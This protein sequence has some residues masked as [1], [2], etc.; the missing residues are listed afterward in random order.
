MNITV[1]PECWKDKLRK[2]FA[3][4]YF[5]KLQWSIYDARKETVVLPD[6]DLVLKA[7]E[8]TPLDK[9]KVVILGQDPYP[10]KGNANG[11]AFGVPSDLHV[12][13]SLRN[14]LLEIVSEYHCQ[15]A[16]HG[17]L[18]AW[19]KQG[20]LLLNSTLTVEEGKPG[21]HEGLG[22]E[23]FTDAI[24]KKLSEEK[25]N[26][27]FLLWGQKAGEKSSLIDSSRHLVLRAA[28]PSPLSAHRGFF[29]C[30]HFKKANAYLVEHGK[31]RINWSD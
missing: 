16:K 20:V 9:V 2:E 23:R 14:I 17:D 26:V 11:L 19:A 4:P 6:D 21:S 13:G 22:W 30:G 3:A 12:P 15:V 7:L 28:H 25:K 8:L 5:I 24:V 1:L 29:G 27:V 31:S 10:T 18:T